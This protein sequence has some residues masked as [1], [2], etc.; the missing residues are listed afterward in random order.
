MDRFDDLGRERREQDVK[1]VGG[2]LALIL[3]CQAG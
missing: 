2:C 3:G 1:V